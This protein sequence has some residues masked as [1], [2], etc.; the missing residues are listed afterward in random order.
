MT[1]ATHGLRAVSVTPTGAMLWLTGHTG[2]WWLKQT[3]PSAGTCT[4]G[5]ADL[6]H[7]LGNLTT[8]TSYTWTAYSNSSCTTVIDTATFTPAYAAGQRYA[9]KDFDT[10]Y[11]A[12]N[13]GPRGL[14]SDGTTLWV[15]DRDDK[16]IYAYKLS[17]TSRDAAKDFNTLDAAGNQNPAGIWSDGTTMWVAD[18]DDD[19]LYAYNLA[20]K[21]RDA[22]KDF[23]TLAAAGNNDPYG[24]WSDGTTMYVVGLY[25]RQ[26]LRLQ[27][28]RPRPATPARTSTPW[29]RR[30][31]TARWACGRTASPYGWGTGTTT[32]STPTG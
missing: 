4:A 21:A 27:D 10:L 2:D 7:A 14:W 1:F 6:S 30:A 12:G 26:A 24:L 16:K 22:A 18:R 17:D 5:E 11:A 19:K 32:R 31:T 29:P 23:T 20:T 9:G 13:N 25:R 8:G 15:S 3:S 28:V